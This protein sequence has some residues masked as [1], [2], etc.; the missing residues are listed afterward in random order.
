MNVLGVQVE[1]G[2]VDVANEGALAGEAVREF[3]K[4]YEI[5]SLGRERNVLRSAVLACVAGCLNSTARVRRWQAIVSHQT[6]DC[7]FTGV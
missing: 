5:R 4:V 1:G 7:T 3:R 2:P 6:C